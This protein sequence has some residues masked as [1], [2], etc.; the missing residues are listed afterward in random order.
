MRR[1]FVATTAALALTA[2]LAGVADAGGGKPKNVKKAKA[3]IQAAYECFLS[4]ALGY[5]IEQKAACVQDIADDP[6]LLDLAR[7]VDNANAGASAM[8]EPV[9]NK[10]SF[11]S[12]KRANVDFDLEVGGELLG[13]IAPSGEAVLVKE[14]G[15]KVWKVSLATFC[16]LSALGYPPAAAQG[17]CAAILAEG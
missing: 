12:P 6:A 7:Q 5:T 17:P 16:K 13:D 4:G 3:D 11:E 15:E 9:I 8:T 2:L 10:I 1:L 14:T